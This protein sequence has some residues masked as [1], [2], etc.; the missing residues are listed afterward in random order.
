MPAEG[1]LP[2]NTA[3]AVIRKVFETQGGE[4]WLEVT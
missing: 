4:Q 3:L 1:E 2:G